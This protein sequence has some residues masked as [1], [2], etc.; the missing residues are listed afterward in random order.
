M[1]NMKHVGYR[2]HLQMSVYSVT[3]LTAKLKNIGISTAADSP[4]HP[5]ALIFSSIKVAAVE[6]TSSNSKLES[7]L[8][9]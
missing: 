4:K 3:K 1:D 6:L 9:L 8:H 5:T 2:V 7:L